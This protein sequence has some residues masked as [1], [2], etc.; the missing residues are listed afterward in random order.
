M[1]V[2]LNCEVG[3]NYTSTLTQFGGCRF[4]DIFQEVYEE[5][6][7]QKFEEHSIWLVCVYIELWFCRP[8]LGSLQVI[9]GNS[10]T[11]IQV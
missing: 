3:K 10:V 2:Y 9:Y 4:K 1:L 6:W 8:F 11:E 7:K 5:N